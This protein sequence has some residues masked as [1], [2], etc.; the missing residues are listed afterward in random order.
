MVDPMFFG[1][2]QSKDEDPHDNL[3]PK[4]SVQVIIKHVQ[5]G[6]KI[7]REMGL[8]D[9]IVDFIKQHHGTQ[10]VE[11]FYNKAV[12]ANSGSKL[13]KEDFRYPGPK[14]QSLETAILMIVDAVEATF[15]SLESPSREKIEKTIFLSIVKRIADGQFSECNLSTRDL[16]KI[17]TTLTDSLEATYHPR[18]AYPWQKKKAKAGKRKKR[19]D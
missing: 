19:K 6:E 9:V 4:K 13:S 15:R 3:D 8:P 14:P 1:E 18:V 16:A 10:L 12:Q 5:D 17:V 11:Y 7:A 2:N